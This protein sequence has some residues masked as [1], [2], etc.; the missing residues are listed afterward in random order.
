MQTGFVSNM[1]SHKALNF[2]IHRISNNNMS[3]IS[4]DLYCVIMLSARIVL[5]VLFINPSNYIM[6][7]ECRTVFALFGLFNSRWQY[8]RRTSTLQPQ[9]QL[10]LAH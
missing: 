4:L 1:C 6:K 2:E 9:P 5:Y 7:K 10:E 3:F 8:V